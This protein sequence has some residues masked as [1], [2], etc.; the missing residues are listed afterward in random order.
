MAVFDNAPPLFKYYRSQ[1]VNQPPPIID[2]VLLSTFHALGLF[3]TFQIIEWQVHV[4]NS[5]SL[6]DSMY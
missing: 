1:L 2:S 4:W 5:A 6:R 3:S